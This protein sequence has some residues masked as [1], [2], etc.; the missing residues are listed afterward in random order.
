MG[1]SIAPSTYITHSAK[2]LFN[3]CVVFKVVLEINPILPEISKGKLAISLENA[4]ILFNYFFTILRFYVALETNLN[5]LYLM[6]NLCCI[7][8]L[9]IMNLFPFF[10]QDERNQVFTSK[11]WVKQVRSKVL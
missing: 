4:W 10:L 8:V 11:V 5:K 2:D 3:A 9:T 6:Y 1:A 7:G